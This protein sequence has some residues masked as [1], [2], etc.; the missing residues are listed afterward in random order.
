MEIKIS[1]GR[2]DRD[3]RTTHVTIMNFKLYMLLKP[4]ISTMMIYGLMIFNSW[5][6]IR[7][8][9]RLG[10]KTLVR[11][12]ICKRLMFVAH[13]ELEVGSWNSIPCPFS[14]QPWCFDSKVLV[15]HHHCLNFTMFEFEQSNLQFYSY[16]SQCMKLL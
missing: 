12:M 16:D 15:V 1:K 14:D 10:N 4:R 11:H 8:C 3:A 5:K 9:K 2:I 6:F 13:N 7:K